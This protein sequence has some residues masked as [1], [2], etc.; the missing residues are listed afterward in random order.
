MINNIESLPF[1]QVSEIVFSGN[2]T[3][4]KEKLRE[5]SGIIL[6]QTSLDWFELFSGGGRIGH[7]SMGGTGG[8]EKNWP[9]T[10]EISIVENV[11]VALLH[12]KNQWSPVAIYRQE[13]G[14]VSSG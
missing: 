6:H 8:C 1:F 10:V 12:S 3:I 7:C 4:S 14:A 2:E 13:R 11:P 5:A 9:S